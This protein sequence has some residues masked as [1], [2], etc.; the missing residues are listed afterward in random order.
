MHKS[1]NV[2]TVILKVFEVQTIDPFVHGGDM[3]FCQITLT[4]CYHYDL[5]KII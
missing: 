4:I 1:F 5:Q 3:A 2:K